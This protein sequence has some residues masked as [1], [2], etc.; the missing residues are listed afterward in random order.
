LKGATLQEKAGI[1]GHS[2]QHQESLDYDKSSFQLSKIQKKHQT[3]IHLA[4]E[5][6]Y[7][8]ETQKFTGVCLNWLTDVGPVS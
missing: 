4:R 2:H 1:L 3:S 6:I 7:H 8:L 5:I